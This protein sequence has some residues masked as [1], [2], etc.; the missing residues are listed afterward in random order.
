M[1]DIRDFLKPPAHIDPIPA[2][3]VD[4]SY[5]RMRMQMMLGIFVGYAGYYLIRKNFSLAMP[6]LIAMGYTKAELGFA[7]SGVSLAYGLSKFLMGNVSDRSDARKFVVLGLS[8]SAL[9]T[10]FLGSVPLATSSITS[11]FVLLSLSGWFQGIGYP[12][13]VRVMAHWF[14]IRERGVKM[15][16]WNT[17]HNVGGGLVGPLAILAV[18]LFADWHSKIYLHGYVALVFAFVTWFLVRDTPQ[19]CGLP[20]IEQWT[21]DF[22]KSYSH[23]NEREMSAKEILFNHVLNNKLLWYLA[24]ANI[25]VYLVRY[26]VLD[27]APTYL[28]EVKHFSMSQTGWAYFAYEFAGI[29]GILITG[30]LS[31]KVFYGRRAPV[32]IIF[33]LLVG[34]AVFIYWQNPPGNPMIDIACLIAVGFLIYGP[35]VLIGVQALDMAPKKAAGTATGLTGLFGYL[36]GAVFANM[37]MGVIVDRFGWRGGFLVLIG[38]CVLGALFV[39]FTISEERKDKAS[40]YSHDIEED[41]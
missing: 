10:I 32:N 30:W 21:G 29:P 41:P 19:S 4:T 8:V 16:I 38:S 12:S 7:L 35:V 28:E 2:D 6:D 33:M 17:A 26:G 20:S 1:T 18:A 39:C 27:W 3:Q 23:D 22:H 36:G 13:C 11:M 40:L 14:T 31:D 15:A 9:I 34:V 25:F 37:A 5:K 24:F